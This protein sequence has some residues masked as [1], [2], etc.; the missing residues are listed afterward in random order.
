[1]GFL[2]DLGKGIVNGVKNKMEKLE[3]LKFE[4]ESYSDDELARKVK[5]GSSD[6]KQVAF[7][8]LKGRGYSSE[9]IR[10][11]VK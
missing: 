8:V 4:Y 2:S 11:M 1:M 3:A 10:I 7:S 5:Y 9:D 6:Q